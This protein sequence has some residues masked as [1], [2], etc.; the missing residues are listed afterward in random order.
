[1]NL[2]EVLLQNYAT[3]TSAVETHSL[4]SLLSR[5]F[6]SV[7]IAKKHILFINLLSLAGYFGYVLC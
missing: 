4:N 1:L 3:L 2:I 5:I 6:F 7:L